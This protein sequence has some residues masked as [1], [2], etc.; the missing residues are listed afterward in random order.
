M[1]EKMR[2]ARG[3][4]TAIEMDRSGARAQKS[5][6]RPQEA[7]LARAVALVVGAGFVRLRQG[8]RWSLL[9]AYLVV[10]AGIPPLIQPHLAYDQ[11]ADVLATHINPAD[12]IILETG[13]DDNAFAY[14]I[15]QRLGYDASIIRT[16]PWVNDRV[17]PIQVVSQIGEALQHAER[18]WVVNWYQPSQLLPYLTNADN[19]FVSILT[20][21]ASVGTDYQ[22]RF[23]YAGADDHVMIQGFAQPKLGDE[24]VSFGAELILR[25]ALFS[26]SVQ[27]DQPL[28]VDAW[29][30]VPRSLALD[31][32][33][34]VFLLAH[35]G[36]VIADYNGA[37]GALP[38]STWQP[39]QLQ[40]TRYAI[41][42]DALSR[43]TYELV[44]AVYH[45]ETPAQPLMV[46]DAPHLALG[47][48]NVR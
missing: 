15:R 5:R 13:W 4:F 36:T 22:G 46:N 8:A 24:G 29:W 3:V 7:C 16:L 25:E 27:A 19:G 45:Y 12:L 20:T 23:A 38:T 47:L 41:R 14:E 43:G 18:V 42:T 9:V 32:S 35:D 28:Y 21:Q 34:G 30:S 11:T 2:L 10:S 40:Q 33:V 44:M 48:V 17:E 31:Y 1:A 37:V 26:A 39:N 6:E